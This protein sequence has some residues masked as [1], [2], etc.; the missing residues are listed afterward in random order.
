MQG[1]SDEPL[2]A[3]IMSAKA[4]II[5]EFH[6]HCTKSESDQFIFYNLA[7]KTIGMM[8]WWTAEGYWWILGVFWGGDVKR[9]NNIY[10]CSGLGWNFLN[11]LCKGL[12]EEF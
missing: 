5:F 6:L 9:R 1:H 8:S 4:S 2:R 12:L 11:S 3:K 7:F 10:F